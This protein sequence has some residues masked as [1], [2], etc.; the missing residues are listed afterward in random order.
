MSEIDKMRQIFLLI[1]FGMINIRKMEIN[2]HMMDKS[3]ML[4]LKAHVRSLLYQAEESTKKQD[5]DISNSTLSAISKS[6]KTSSEVQPNLVDI[7]SSGLSLFEHTLLDS[8]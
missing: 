5:L 3:E 4:E 2:K 6:K 8:E 7:D 1:L